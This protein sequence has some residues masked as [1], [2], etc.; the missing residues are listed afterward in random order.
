M[1]TTLWIR[2][3]S[4]FLDRPDPDPSLFCT[5]PDSFHQQAKKSKKRDLDFYYFAT[6]I[7]N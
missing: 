1:F 5:D 7:E 6:L 3:H 4:L 2:I